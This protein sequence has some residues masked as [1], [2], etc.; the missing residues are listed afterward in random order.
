MQ[1]AE[2]DSCSQDSRKSDH[3][4]LSE[5]RIHS[6]DI[7]RA[8]TTICSSDSLNDCEG[9][10]RAV[11]KAW[12]DAHNSTHLKSSLSQPS[13]IQGILEVLHISNN[14]EILELG[15]SILAEI[16]AQSEANR[17]CV[18][19]TDPHLSVS[20]RLMRNN[21][22][23]LKAAVLLYLLKPKAKQMVSTEWIPLVLRVLEFGDQME[24]LFSVKCSPNE[25]AYYLL[26][27]LLTGF[28][29]DKNSD[30]AKEIIF[31]R[32]LD[33]LVRRMEVGDGNEK[34]R[35]AS[36]LRRCIGAD[37]SCRHYLVKNLKKDGILGLLV[38]ENRGNCE[39]GHALALLSELLCISR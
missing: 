36:V 21:N 6:T 14:D 25:A 7:D 2:A 31:S 20:I 29:E 3:V 34:S 8:L 18:L 32:G 22:L 10:I 33:L 24:T 15:V 37:G 35:V 27:Q 9:S 28:D 38:D 17:Q 16:T 13:I 19:T 5:I 11:S 1:K 26:D 12:L 23:F 30:N 39:E 4:K